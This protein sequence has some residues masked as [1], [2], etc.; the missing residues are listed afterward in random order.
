VT[1]VRRILEVVLIAY[2]VGALALAAAAHLAPVTG[3]ALLAVRSP[4]MAPALGIGDL[5]IARRVPAEEVRP[6][7]V[8]MI[9]LASGTMV[10]HR[11]VAITATDEGPMF[12][13]RGDANAAA[14][15]V[16]ARAEQLQ[17]RLAGSVAF[18]GFILAMLSMPS[19][20]AAL[21]S[22]GASLLVALWLL[23]EVGNDDALED[24]IRT[25]EAEGDVGRPATAPASPATP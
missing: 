25:L 23:D 3:H 21:F 7:D 5:A 8:I 6:D 16:A 10:T 14:D 1:L 2:V 15:P 11:V 18:L 13:T 24:L 19:G 22:I 17:G 20:I 4:S 12:T 9:R